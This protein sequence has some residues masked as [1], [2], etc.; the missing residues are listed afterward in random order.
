METL[1]LPY[2]TRGLEPY[3]SQECLASHYH[4]YQLGIRQLKFLISDTIFENTDL[5]T[6]IKISEGVL[7]FN[8][9]QVWNHAFYFSGLKPGGSMLRKGSFMFAINGCFG[10]FKSLKELLVKH[11]NRGEASGWI[12]L[13]VNPDGAIEII[14]D[15]GSNHPLLKGFWPVFNCDL[16]EHSFKTDFGLNRT[17][18]IETVLNLADWEIIEIRYHN[19]LKQI[20]GISTNFV[21]GKQSK[22]IQL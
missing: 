18:Y 4:Q 12:W 2:K 14:R 1:Q 19:A 6:L 13:V 9:I 7:Q 22:F 17:A 10:S 21:P 16:W 11:G 8:A 3:F 5:T 20:S 15:H